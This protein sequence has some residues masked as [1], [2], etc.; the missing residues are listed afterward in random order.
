MNVTIVFGLCAYLIA[1]I[2]GA[3]AYLSLAAALGPAYQRFASRSI[4][5]ILTRDTLPLSVIATLLVYAGF[6]RG[7]R[8]GVL[9]D[10]LAIA[11]GGFLLAVVLQGKGFGYHYLAAIGVSVMLLVL[12]L[13]APPVGGPLRRACALVCAALVLAGALWPFLDATIRRAQGNLS[14]VDAAMIGAAAV[15]RE[16]AEGKGVAVLSPRL[17]D[18]FPLVL[19]AQARWTLRVPNLWCIAGPVAMTPTEKWCAASVGEDLER[20]RPEVVLIRNWEPGGPRDL[21]FDFMA[22]VRADPRFAHEL[23]RYRMVATLPQFTVWERRP[24]EGAR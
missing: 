10:H 9:A 5:T 11:A 17:A 15:V 19:Y 18:A 6:R 22:P 4:V 3:P 13:A 1:V 2:V 14:S 20:A 8:W 23:L 24:A 16:R 21:A 7:T 12:M